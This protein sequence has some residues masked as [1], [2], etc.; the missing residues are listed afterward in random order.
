M[1]TITMD[2]GKEFTVTESVEVVM[3]SLQMANRGQGRGASAFATLTNYVTD[4]PIYINVD[5]ISVVT[6]SEST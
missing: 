4:L 1:T 3:T 2:D 6:E 5:H